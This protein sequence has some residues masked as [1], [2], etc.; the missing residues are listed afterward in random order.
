MKRD[1]AIAAFLQIS[2][3]GGWLSLG[4]ELIFIG[5]GVNEEW[6]KPLA[7]DGTGAATPVASAAQP[8]TTSTPIIATPNTSSRFPEPKALSGCQEIKQ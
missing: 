7:G 6:R 4:D 5:P 3:R 8:V 2:P 1:A